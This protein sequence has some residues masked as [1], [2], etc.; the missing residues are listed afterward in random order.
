[1]AM[2]EGA[3]APLWLPLRETACRSRSTWTQYCALCLA[4]DRAPFFRRSWQL[5]SR[6]S[7][8]RH[9]CGLRDRCPA[10]RGGMAPFAQKELI[11]HYVGLDPTVVS[12]A[13]K[14]ILSRF[15]ADRRPDF[16]RRLLSKAMTPQDGVLWI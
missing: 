8:F 13:A 11:P 15:C 2:T 6:I 9:G 12:P 5:A 14:S 16:Y 7:C 4:E 3:L 10:C 1:M